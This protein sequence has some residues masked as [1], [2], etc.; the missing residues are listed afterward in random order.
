[1]I[2][3]GKLEE[4]RKVRVEEDE[5]IIGSTASVA[6][7]MENR[8]LME[9][10]PLL[11]DAV[12]VFGSRQIRSVATIG[13]NIANASPAADL[14]PVLLVLGAEV[15]IA[16]LEGKR[17]AQMDEL[18]GSYRQNGVRGG[19][20]ITAV[21]IPKKR[22]PRH[23]YRKIGRRSSL[24]IA[25]ASLA[26][27]GEERENGG[28]TVRLGGASLSP[29]PRRM[30]HTEAL[31]LCGETLSYQAVTEAL[32]QDIDPRSGMRGSA[33]YRLRVCAN[34]VMEFADAMGR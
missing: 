19:E 20:I 13:G 18:I 5:V 24:N 9:L 26:A 3:L 14:I 2:S 4:L 22:W 11:E 27:V 25:V 34:M 12:G 15:E 29:T 32:K 10:F 16:G 21:R 6:E 28:W 1:M 33:E 17:S 8:E 7:M 30:I 31:F 23:Y